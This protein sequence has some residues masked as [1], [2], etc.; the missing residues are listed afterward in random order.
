MDVDIEEAPSS[1]KSE[2]WWHFGFPK[3]KNDSG[4]VVDKTKTVCKHCKKTFTY[5]ISTTNMS[6]TNRHHSE[7]LQSQLSVC[8]KLLIGQT[9]LTGGFAAPLA[10]TSA[11][12]AEITQCI[13]VFMGK[14][15]RPFS[16]VENVR[17]P[18]N[19]LEPRYQIPSRPHFSQTVMPTLYRE[20]NTQKGRQHVNYN[21]QLDLQGYPELSYGHSPCDNQR[22]GDGQF[23]PFALC[24]KHTPGLI[25]LKF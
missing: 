21:R 8:K 9:T 20:T 16:V 5:I 13:C 1:F 22:V 15:M 19:T 18:V 10:P 24:L 14:D 23:C 6:S 3:T 7:K 17:L 2:V 12:A 4:E 11:R 25:L